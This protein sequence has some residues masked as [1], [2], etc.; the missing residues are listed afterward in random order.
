MK[1]LSLNLFLFL[2]FI[3]TNSFS[4]QKNT[5]L[6]GDSQVGCVNSRMN[7]F[8]T[9]F[10]IDE[11]IFVDYKIGSTIQFWETNEKFHKTLLQYPLID[12]VI[13]FLGTNNFWQTTKPNVDSILNEIESKKLNCIWVGPTKVHDKKLAINQLLKNVV[14]PTC[15]YVDT[16]QFFIPLSDGIH[17]TYQ[18]IFKW[19][20]V[21][22]E[23]K[24]NNEKFYFIR[25]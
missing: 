23:K 21:I 17:P 13:I 7:E 1:F 25:D 9:K 12:T 5:L 2:I 19:L 4:N 22:W 3:S 11:N 15:S 20:R 14:S 24:E 16:E 10:N 6:I 8:K 18:G